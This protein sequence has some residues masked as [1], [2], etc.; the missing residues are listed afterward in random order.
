L[1]SSYD[2]CNTN[3]IGCVKQVSVKP[4]SHAHNQ[5]G[6]YFESAGFG[7]GAA[8]DVLE[9]AFGSVSLLPTQQ[10]SRR[11]STLAPEQRLCLAVLTDAII[12]ITRKRRRYE[13]DLLWIMAE[14][15][16]APFS[17]EACCDALDID[18]DALCEALQHAIEA[19]NFKIKRR[20]PVMRYMGDGA[21]RPDRERARGR[22]GVRKHTPV[23][24]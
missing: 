14:V 18:H 9:H 4:H 24:A 11:S 23:H 19:T 10:I 2:G 15:D 16:G 12:S 21:I 20:S 13:D 22:H 6:T 17:A 7:L 3:R 5:A 8:M 1:A